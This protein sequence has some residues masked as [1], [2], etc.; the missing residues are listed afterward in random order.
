MQYVRI[1]FRPKILKSTLRWMMNHWQIRVRSFRSFAL[2]VHSKETRINGG[3]S[4]PH[5][6]LENSDGYDEFKNTF[7]QKNY[8]FFEY[9]SIICVYHIIFISNNIFMDYVLLYVYRRVADATAENH[10]RVPETWYRRVFAYCRVDILSHVLLG[11]SA[12]V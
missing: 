2:C 6:Q 4:D 10:R 8:M 11:T 3:Q 1:L 5:S 9:Y 12:H 7:A